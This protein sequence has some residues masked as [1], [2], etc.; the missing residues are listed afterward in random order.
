MLGMAQALLADDQREQIE[1]ILDSCGVL[2]G[3]LNDVLL[4]GLKSE[5]FNVVLLDIHMPVMNGLEAISAIQAGDETWSHI[6]VIAL[7]AKCD[8]RRPGALPG[9][10]H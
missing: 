6:P 7:T 10:R 4:E 8:G 2:M 9:D 5:V 1:V 3:L